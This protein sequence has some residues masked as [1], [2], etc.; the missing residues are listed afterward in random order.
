MNGEEL[1]NL[2]NFLVGDNEDPFDDTSAT[3]LIYLNQVRE[4]VEAEE[5]WEFLKTQDRS[6]Y[7]CGW[8]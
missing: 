3:D 2:A 4:E 7:Y 5:E 1:I 8:L 6:L